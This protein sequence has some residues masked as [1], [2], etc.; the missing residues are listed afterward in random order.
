MKIYLSGL[1]GLSCLQ[2][3]PVCTVYL[4]VREPG[5]PN[6]TGASR[7]SGRISASLPPN[8]PCAAES[9]SKKRTVQLL[10]WRLT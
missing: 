9:S 6:P 1:L 7:G 2:L 4:R 10:T 3:C 8:A 5:F